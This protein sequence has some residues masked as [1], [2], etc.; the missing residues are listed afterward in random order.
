MISGESYY[1]R[2]LM[3][4]VIFSW[5][6]I[7]LIYF[8]A[9]DSLLSQLQQ[10]VLISPGS[11]NTFWLL[12]LTGIPQFLLTNKV[13]A[14]SFDLVVTTSCLVCIFIPAQ[15][16]FTIITVAG[17]W[18]L[19]VCYSTAAGKH[20]VQI[21]YLLAP[22][23]FFALNSKRFSLLWEG[24]RYWVCFLFV[25]A[26]LYKLYYGGFFDAD[27]M[28]NI[29]LLENAQ[30]LAFEPGSLQRNLIEF[31]IENKAAAQW[32]YRLAAVLQFSLLIGFFTRKYDDW[33]FCL[34]LLFHLANFILLHISFVDQSLIFAPFL[35]WKRWAQY[36]QLT[37]GND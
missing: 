4:Q 1:P 17:V 36:F 15:R 34:L 31:L 11:D 25:C 12:H 26:G 3:A 35:P 5:L 33:L 2:Q 9:T 14:L 37:T 24:L 28:R 23:P 16:A 30:W 32:L 10:P 29:L 27:N 7:I 6:F 19:Y 8:F 13:A 18:L 22:L 20:Y 21:G